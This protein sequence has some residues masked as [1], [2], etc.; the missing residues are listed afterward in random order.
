MRTIPIDND[1]DY[2]AL[3]RYID[4]I[5]KPKGYKLEQRKGSS[6]WTDTRPKPTDAAVCFKLCMSEKGIF[7][8]AREEW[9]KKLKIAPASVGTQ[10]EN[11]LP[12]TVDFRGEY[13]ENDVAGKK[14]IDAICALF[15]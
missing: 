9:V 12:S 15:P 10:L 4:S 11:P 5:L 2:R 1:A 13:V 7:F 14:W 8:G 3:E 6:S